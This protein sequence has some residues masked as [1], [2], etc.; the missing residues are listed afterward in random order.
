MSRASMTGSLRIRRPD[1]G[2]VVDGRSV[3][4]ELFVDTSAWYALA[5]HNAPAVQAALQKRL[6]VRTRLVTTNL[7]MAETQVLLLRRSGRQAALA[8]LREVRQPPTVVVQSTAELEER[9]IL[10]WLERFEDQPF[11]FTDAVSFAT[12]TEYGI[13]EALTLDSHFAIAG[14]LMIP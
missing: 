1:R 14:F 5:R 12:M 7:V 11:S 6:R 13:R 2:N 8:F 9:A 10:R 3:P 4:A